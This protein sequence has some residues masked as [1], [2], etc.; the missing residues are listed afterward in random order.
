MID[1][2][3]DHYSSDA[4]FDDFFLSLRFSLRLGRLN[5]CHIPFDRAK[6]ALQN[7]KYHVSSAH[8]IEFQK[9][10]IQKFSD[11]ISV[12]N[13][14]YIAKLTIENNWSQSYFMCVRKSIQKASF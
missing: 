7:W 12:K 11:Q 8:L 10:K 2:T 4:K 14:K 9:V 6:F 5:S 13:F 3:V 1:H